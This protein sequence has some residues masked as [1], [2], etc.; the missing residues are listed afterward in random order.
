MIETTMIRATETRSPACCR[1]RAAAV[2]NSVASAWPDEAPLATSITQSAPVRAS[3][4]PSPV[5]TSTPCLR[6]IGTTSC[7]RTLSNVA[8]GGRPCRSR[9][10]DLLP[11]FH[12]SAAHLCRGW[13]P[14][15]G[16]GRL[17]ETSAWAGDVA[18]GMRV[19]Q[20]ERCGSVPGIC[21]RR[22]WRGVGACFL[23]R[24]K[25]HCQEQC[26][27]SEA[28][29]GEECVVVGRCLGGPDEGFVIACRG[30]ARGDPVVGDGGHDREPQCPSS[31]LAGVDEPST[32][33]CLLLADPGERGDLEGHVA[34]AAAKPDR[35]E[36]RQEV[37]G[38]AAADGGPP[39]Q[40]KPGYRH[41]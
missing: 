30:Q 17:L 37:S 25:E 11:G 23:A 16:L 6:E 10:S 13:S 5:R 12:N 36:R 29:G 38:I 22:Y 14:R 9:H 18:G 26:G 27:E 40:Q 7:A 34:Q 15:C 39:Q 3:A 41:H 31:F 33:A 19:H 28:C 20:V 32:D 24:H 8:S 2:K 21:Y 1:L 4:S 35:Q